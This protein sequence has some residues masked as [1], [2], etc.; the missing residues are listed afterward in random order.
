MINYR[1]KNCSYREDEVKEEEKILDT[2][3]AGLHVGS[4][5]SLPLARWQENM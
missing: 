4:L 3:H 2:L 1:F 5:S